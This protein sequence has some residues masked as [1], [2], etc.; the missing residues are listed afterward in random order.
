M[1]LSV[2]KSTSWKLL[3]WDQFRRK[4]FNLQCR[5][6][7]AMR[8]NDIGKTIKLQKCLIHSSATHFIAIKECTEFNIGHKT[9]ITDA[10]LLSTFKE[11]LL[12]A[13][14]IKKDISNWKHSPNKK[15][16]L[17]I[18]N[19]INTFF[20]I[21]TIEDRIIHFIWKL[22][23]EPAHEATFFESSYGF[24]PGRTIWDM[25]KT[26]I[27]KLTSL[28]KGSF[29][30]VF[31]LDFSEHFK[32][33]NHNLLIKKLIFPSK[34]KKC[35]YQALQMGII[36]GALLPFSY[37]YSLT[38]LSF[39]LLNI[40]FHG[41]DE[42]LINNLSNNRKVGI[43]RY[44]PHFLYISEKDK[45]TVCSLMKQFFY[46][47][48]ITNDS[49]EGLTCQSLNNFDFLGWSF[50]IKPSGKIITYPTK[51]HWIIHKSYIKAILKNSRNNTFVRL[52][53]IERKMNRWYKY[54]QFCTISE[55]SLQIY[56][57][58]NWINRSLRLQTNMSKE[59]RY[60][61]VRKIFNSTSSF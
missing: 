42:L 24:R 52:T 36:D 51:A 26:I 3:P 30:K 23:L 16:T 56:S 21:P 61:L 46:T 15:V 13:N 18:D 17:S 49:L 53:K 20:S 1:E 29:K 60:I 44:G 28:S 57:L 47:I 27:A 5:I 39:L 4:V 11:K 58:R 54:H 2:Y 41:L 40:A 14:L 8:N 10:K 6:Y 9:S 25:H 37:N 33:S 48:G 45:Y 50:V 35:I 55:L 32:L 31:I 7:D 19:G 12:L 59:E 38:T 22:A 43:F 34:Y